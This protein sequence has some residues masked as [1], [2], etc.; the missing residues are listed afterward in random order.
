MDQ[1][2]VHI[3]DVQ[4]VEAFV[5]RTQEFVVGKI[6]PRHLRCKKYVVARHAGRP[7]GPTY[8][9]FVAVIC[10]CV[11]VAIAD[12]QRGANCRNAFFAGQSH[13]SETQ[14]RHA[15]SLQLDMVH[16]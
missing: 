14:C 8:L 16:R 12:L 4:L 9:C 1:E 3:L 2:K 15:Q 10:R 7:Y 11:D 5:K 6:I 13:G